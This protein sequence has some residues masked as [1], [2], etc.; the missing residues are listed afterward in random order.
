MNA[1]FAN[2]TPAVLPGRLCHDGFEFCDQSGPVS[3]W[4]DV[5]WIQRHDQIVRNL[6][7]GCGLFGK[8]VELAQNL[9]PN[10][11]RVHPTF[12]YGCCCSVDKVLKPSFKAA[13]KIHVLIV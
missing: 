8:K 4:V 5:E 13:R 12:E 11:D 10:H 2:E 7:T 1:R 9:A 3:F 6:R